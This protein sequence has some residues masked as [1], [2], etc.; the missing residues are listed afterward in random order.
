MFKP[1]TVVLFVVALAV[2]Y[3]LT[4]P[5]SVS[6][7]A[8]QAP[9]NKGL[10]GDFSANN[11]LA[12]LEIISLSGHEGP[13]DLAVSDTGQVYFSLLNGNIMRLTDDNQAEL[14]AQT[15]GRPLGIEFSPSGELIVADAFKG[16]LSVSADGAAVTLLTDTVLGE[17]IAYANDVDIADNGDIYFSDASSKFSASASDTYSAS[18]LDIMEHGGH[19][20]LLKY[21]I[22]TRETSVVLEDL[23]FANG[24]AIAHEQDAILISETGNYRILKHWISG[25]KTGQTQVL[26]SNLPGFPDNLNRGNNGQYWFGLVSPRSG[27]LDKLSSF[28]KLRT[29]IQRLP[30]TIRPK[31]QAL[32]HVVAIDG[33]GKVQQSL[34]D[35]NQSYSY[36]TGAV[37]SGKWLY[38]SSLH[39]KALA[40][41]ALAD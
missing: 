40:R 39:E 25:E 24:I 37:E 6:P 8:W 28:P 15:G 29:M 23:Q 18:L 11:K 1:L 22:K 32:G 35:A 26:L 30:A 21:S 3:L 33:H 2:I 5:V 27:I 19:G 12:A 34:Q 4:W 10:V 13:E 20:R 9:E 38:M 16:L 17:T 31:A 7:V 36:T 14:F 41:I